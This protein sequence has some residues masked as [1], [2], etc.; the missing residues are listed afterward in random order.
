[1][2]SKEAA[3]DKRLRYVYNESLEEF[4]KKMEEQDF[5]CPLCGRLFSQF[6]P[7]Q[8]HDHKCCPR[9]LKRFCGKCNRGLLCFICNKYA[10]GV[11]EKLSNLE[12]P[13]DFEKVLAYIKEWN[14]KI[15][16]KGGY[17]P[18]AEPKKKKAKR[19]S[20]KQKSVRQCDGTLPKGS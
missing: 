20:K 18:K 9:R 16:A 17:A 13:V 1:M 19:T 15:K 4:N 5:K 14:E 8:D 10:M 3:R 2:T 6:Q 11:I 12:Q 7:Y